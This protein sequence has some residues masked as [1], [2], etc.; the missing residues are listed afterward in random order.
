MA[1]G[2]V[3]IGK[4]CLVKCLAMSQLI[5]EL[6]NNVNNRQPYHPAAQDWLP[7]EAKQG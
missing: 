4:D 6:I 7:T 5:F 3:F 2:S 1:N